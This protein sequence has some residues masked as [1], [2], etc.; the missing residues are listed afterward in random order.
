M[1]S[2]EFFAE[3]ERIMHTLNANEF[4]GHSPGT[5]FIDRF[6]GNSKGI[7]IRLRLPPEHAEI[8]ASV[9]WRDIPGA[10]WIDPPSVDDRLINNS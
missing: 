4:R 1:T 7:T 3:G 6:C 9:E 5:V 8:Y 10:T 2:E